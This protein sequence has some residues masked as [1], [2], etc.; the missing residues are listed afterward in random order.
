MDKKQED[1]NLK[2]KKKKLKQKENKK[3]LYNN[4]N[5]LYII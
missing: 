1:Y 5:N 2:Y 4:I 3:K